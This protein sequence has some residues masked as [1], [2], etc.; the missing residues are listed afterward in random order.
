MTPDMDTT[1]ASEADDIISEY[2]GISRDTLDKVPLPIVVQWRE[3]IVRLRAGF[4]DTAA[5]YDCTK[6]PEQNVDYW[7]GLRREGAALS[8]LFDNI[9][10]PDAEAS[11]FVFED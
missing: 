2:L 8:D 6:A 7:L 3:R 1:V 10:R 5:L 4:S 9:I 11:T